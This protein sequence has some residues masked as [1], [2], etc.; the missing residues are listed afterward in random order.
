MPRPTNTCCFKDPPA[1]RYTMEQSPNIEP[2]TKCPLC[3]VDLDNAT[4]PGDLKTATTPGDLKT[5]TTPLVDHLTKDCEYNVAQLLS[6]FRESTPLEVSELRE[7]EGITSQQLIRALLAVIERQDKIS[8]IL[9]FRLAKL[10][11][12]AVGVGTPESPTDWSNV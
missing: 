4:T 2:L 6:T 5:A 11:I 8:A 9:Q 10:A 7:D 12:R 3:L 1:R